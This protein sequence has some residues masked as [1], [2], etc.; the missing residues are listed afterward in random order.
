MEEFVAT[1]ERI[2]ERERDRRQDFQVVIHRKFLSPVYVRVAVL[3]FNERSLPICV[4]DDADPVI[5]SC[6]ASSSIYALP[7]RTNIEAAL[8]SCAMQKQAASVLS[9]AHLERRI[10]TMHR[11][12]FLLNVVCKV[13]L[14]TKSV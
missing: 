13:L 5:R 12:H 2:I 11:V 8:L 3:I 7:I 10:A 1:Y 9:S 14:T 6:A 4:R